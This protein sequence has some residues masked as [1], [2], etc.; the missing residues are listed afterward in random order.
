MEVNIHRQPGYTAAM[1]LDEQ[2]FVRAR[3]LNPAAVE[4]LLGEFHP[5][6]H[7]LT[8]A[9]T[10][11]DAAGRKA[12]G[13]ILRRGLEHL[14]KWK[15]PD[16]PQRWFLHHTILLT[17]RFARRDPTPADDVLVRPMIDPPPQYTA[18]VRALRKLA[19]Q[20]REALILSDCEKL[21]PRQ[22][23]VAMDCSTEAA[24][25]HLVTA[26]RELGTVVGGDLNIMLANLTRAYQTLT[27]KEQ[28]AIPLV[29]KLSRR[30]IWPRKIWT[31]TKAL[32]T[33]AA[34]VVLA[35]LIWRFRGELE[36]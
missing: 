6:V 16:Q 1:S 4:M 35:Y 15:S 17:R 2:T 33:V 21:D 19:T 31:W 34:L 23:A 20:P 24:A 8:H 18:F 32:L 3:N 14:P 30:F 11:T 22:L 36:F 10:G 13:M 7:R 29:R 5:V 12:T 9:L 28:L 25:N 26:R 27:P